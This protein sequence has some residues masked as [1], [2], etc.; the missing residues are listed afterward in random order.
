[1][2]LLFQRRDWDRAFMILHRTGILWHTVVQST[3]QNVDLSVLPAKTSRSGIHPVSVICF[4]QMENKY[5]WS[6][7]V[8]E[9]VFGRSTLVARSRRP[10]QSITNASRILFER[11]W[12]DQCR[13]RLP[14][15]VPH[16][17]RTH[18]LFDHLANKE[19]VRCQR[20][21]LDQ[22]ALREKRGVPDKFVLQ[23]SVPSL[24]RS[25][26]Q[27]NLVTVRWCSALLVTDR[28]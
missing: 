19:R 8:P 15:H 21:P 1:M 23:L 27:P 26:S 5:G 11:T 6:A 18:K 28:Q 16:S 12:S 22:R 4:G 13:T 10:N 25:I 7:S 24:L 20:H 3:N 9:A 17:R 2:F 14:S